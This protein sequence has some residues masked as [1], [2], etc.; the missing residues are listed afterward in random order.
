MSE[1]KSIIL[2]ETVYTFTF[3]D[4]NG[5]TVPVGKFNRVT[6]SRSLLFTLSFNTESAFERVMLHTDIHN[7][8]WEYINFTRELEENSVYK[9]IIDL[10][11]GGYFSFRFVTE[12]KNIRS[13]EPENYHRLLIDPGVI[14]NYRMY[15]LIPTVSGKL[16]DWT[17]KLE[18]LHDLGFNA[19]HILPFTKMGPSESPYSA[20]DLFSIDDSYID[21]AGDFEKFADRAAEL[22]ISICF[23]MVLNHVSDCSLMAT[24]KA[25]WLVPDSERSDG[26]KRAGCWHHNNWIS[27]E[28]L[29]LI[30]YDH[31]DTS[32][33][34][35][36]YEYMRRY[37]FYWIKKAEK[38]GAVIRLDNLHSSNKYFIRWLLS[39]IKND[40]PAIP[41]LSEYFGSE[42]VLCEGVRSLGLNMLIANTWEYPFAPRLQKYFEYIHKNSNMIRFFT[43][44]TNHD[45]GTAAELFGTSRSSIPRYFCCALMGTGQ[46]GIVQGFE[47]GCENKINFI[48]RNEKIR[49]DT[50]HDFTGF[51]KQTNTLLSEEILFQLNGNIEFI[52]TGEDSLMVS[53]RTDPSTGR[54][55]L[56]AANFNTVQSRSFR[57]PGRADSEPVLSFDSRVYTDGIS[58]NLVMDLSECGVCVLLLKEGK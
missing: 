21:T 48:G 12:N 19:V 6:G 52:D 3:E 36:I 55:Y 31:P 7:K 58:G 43:A 13:W 37:V 38:C 45:T 44:P 5:K 35:D 57:Y 39:E 14:E 22:K 32:I 9:V 42:E 24:E 47:Y 20:A 1:N 16:K 41:F 2:S 11:P 25:H 51:I 4:F 17:E 18:Y 46:T 28:D 56:L 26:L 33:R 29:V 40:F 27:W 23:D 15:T 30:N 50:D 53:I 54:K 10:P 8:N 34:K 49:F